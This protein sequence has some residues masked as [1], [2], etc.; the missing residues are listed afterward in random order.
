M[1]SPFHIQPFLGFLVGNGFLDCRQALICRFLCGIGQDFT[2]II[3]VIFLSDIIPDSIN[4]FGVGKRIR[5]HQNLK[6]FLL[7]LGFIFR[8]NLFRIG[9]HLICRRRLFG[10][11][12]FPVPVAFG[13]HN[14]G[15]ELFVLWRQ[16]GILLQ[17]RDKHITP[18]A[19]TFHPFSV[20]ILA[21]SLP[22]GDKRALR[23]Q[24]VIII[25]LD[26]GDKV[27]LAVANIK[28]S[29]IV[30]VLAADGSSNL[31]IRLVIP[32]DFLAFTLSVL[33]FVQ[34]TEQL[35]SEGKAQIRIAVI[36]LPVVKSR[37]FGKAD[38]KLYS[39]WLLFGRCFCPLLLGNDNFQMVVCG[40][41]LEFFFKI[42]SAVFLAEQRK[43]CISERHGVFVKICD[44]V[45]ICADIHHIALIVE[46]AK[47]MQLPQFLGKFPR[48]AAAE[49][50][51][52][53]PLYL[54][55]KI[56][57]LLNGSRVGQVVFHLFSR[58]IGKVGTL[59]IG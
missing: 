13:S 2:V 24:A 4:I 5:G 18:Q 26:M 49:N 42:L 35:V 48:I 51:C 16:L 47:R 30:K 52:R 34:N 28:A 39:V 12:G 10:F 19:Q 31:K 54:G 1:F 23:R 55:Q 56:K 33:L 40:I 45:L 9:N 44:F 8:S 14:L 32:T 6:A 50:R 27:A 53:F 37:V 20:I 15:K 46:I 17:E 59:H 41:F 36:K 58:N 25:I 22:F 11:F 43:L 57:E 3:G 21:L 7:R 29:L 38:R